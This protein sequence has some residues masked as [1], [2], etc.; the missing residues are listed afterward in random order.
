MN[1]KTRVTATAWLAPALFLVTVFAGVAVGYPPGV[2]ITSKSPSCLSCHADNGPWTDV[3]LTIVDILDK[4]TSA[5]LKQPDGSFLI[6]VP[7]GE[8]RT[9]VTVIGR[10]AGDAA[11]APVRNGWI[12]IDPTLITSDRLTKFPTGWDAN[13][14][15]SC[16]LVGDKLPGYENARLTAL[17]MTLEARPEAADAELVLQAMMTTG[18]AAKGAPNGGLVGNYIER[19]VKFKV[20][21]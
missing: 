20:T 15:L 7:R 3:A 2:G 1:V 21:D 13:L 18:E 11:P 14:P 12:Y 19:K 5:S 16:R 8:R 6:T 10:A 4:D 17:A 9:V